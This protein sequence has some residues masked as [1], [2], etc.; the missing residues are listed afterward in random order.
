MV[1]GILNFFC[2]V[3]TS[4]EKWKTTFEISQPMADLQ[5]V[6]IINNR[7]AK[8]QSTLIQINQNGSKLKISN[9][10]KSLEIFWQT[11][12]NVSKISEVS[13]TSKASIIFFKSLEPKSSIFLSNI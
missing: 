9:I 6:T 12:P 3:E 2:Q 8:Q 10:Q 13:K 5:N 11:S 1:T 7:P 4:C